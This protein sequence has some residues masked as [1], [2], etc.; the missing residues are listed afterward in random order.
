MGE[1]E[2]VA[3]PKDV[4]LLD[5]RFANILDVLASEVTK[6]FLGTYAQKNASKLGVQ[7]NR[8]SF[9]G[10][11]GFFD[12]HRIGIKKFLDENPTYLKPLIRHW[13]KRYPEFAVNVSQKV[14]KLCGASVGFTPQTIGDDLV[15]GLN[16]GGVPLARFNDGIRQRTSIPKKYIQH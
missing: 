4:K 9:L 12:L 16:V 8:S 6:T 14:T 1:D 2:M 15:V 7:P 3:N 13:N 10:A 5:Y 11:D